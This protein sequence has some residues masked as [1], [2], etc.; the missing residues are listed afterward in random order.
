MNL[1]RAR[2]RA[3]DFYGLLPRIAAR[4]RRE[5]LTFVAFDVLAIDDA[6]VIDRPYSQRR[7]L[8]ESLELGGPG[9]VRNAA[10]TWKLGERPRGVC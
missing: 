9:L 6:P 5:P 7:A 2:G 8:L 10:T 4:S 3:R 1:S